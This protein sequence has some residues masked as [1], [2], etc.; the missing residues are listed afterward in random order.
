MLSVMPAL[1]LAGLAFGTLAGRLTT[2]AGEAYGNA[3]SI[4]QQ[5]RSRS[6]MHMLRWTPCV[7]ESVQE[8]SI[9]KNPLKNLSA[10]THSKCALV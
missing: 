6:Y 4:V 1:A 9:L 8:Y 7:S 2:H 5:A 10:Q 3:N